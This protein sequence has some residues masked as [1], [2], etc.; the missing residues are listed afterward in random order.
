MPLHD[1]TRV[2]PNAFHSFHVFWITAFSNAL[3]HGLLPPGYFALPEH[4]A[5]PFAPDIV[6]LSTGGR[7]SRASPAT[8]PSGGGLAVAT[9]VEATLSAGPRKQQRPPQ[10]RVV[11][12]HAEGRQLVA[13]IEIV[14]PGNKARAEAIRSLVDKAVA[15]LDNGIHVSIADVHPN[16]RR[17][18]RGF[19][20]AI[21]RAVRGAEAEYIPNYSRTHSA[22]AARDGGGCLAQLQSSE[23]GAALPNLPLYL[24]PE[25]G[26]ELPL[27]AIYQA[28]WA[29]YPDQLRDE[30]LSEPEA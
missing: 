6:T 21:W 27:E 19:G 8:R 5:P 13:V 9:P 10:R 12:R 23:V 4:I 24:T 15:L 2:T 14:S 26:V 29:M 30:L 20:G 25:G 28:A 17:L 7:G 1:W 16:P 3:N 22:F 18:P 11:V